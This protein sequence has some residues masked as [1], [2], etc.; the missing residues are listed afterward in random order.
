MVSKYLHLQKY[1]D[2]NGKVRD[3]WCVNK[4]ELNFELYYILYNNNTNDT[5]DGRYFS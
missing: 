4:N 2:N 1:N 3:H 5:D